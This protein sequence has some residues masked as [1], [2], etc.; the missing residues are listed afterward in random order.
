MAAMF[1]VHYSTNLFQQAS[2]LTHRPWQ[3]VNDH[4]KHGNRL[5]LKLY[6]LLLSVLFIIPFLL[7]TFSCVVSLLKPWLTSIKSFRNALGMKCKC[8]Y[9]PLFSIGTRFTHIRNSN[10][11]LSWLT[12][13]VSFRYCNIWFNFDYRL[14][15]EVKEKLGISLQNEDVFMATSFGDFVQAVVLKSRGNSERYKQELKF[16]VVE[17]NINNMDINFP[18]QL[19]ING[20]FEDSDSGKTLETINPTDESLICKVS[21]KSRFHYNICEIWEIDWYFLL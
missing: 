2:S 18:H 11:F 7:Y 8:F 3:S 9:M 13:W 14:I 10:L 6:F 1:F 21:E 4:N 19:F 12:D 16:S 17:M 5:I 20:E 15:E